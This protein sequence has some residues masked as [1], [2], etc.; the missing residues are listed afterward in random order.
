MDAIPASIRPRASSMSTRSSTSSPIPPR[1][2]APPRR[3][4]G[5]RS[6][7]GGTD[8]GRIWPQ[9]GGRP[10][11]LDIVG[12]N[13]YHNNQWIHGG[14]PIDR[15]HPLPRPFHRILADTYARYGRPI[16]VAE[17]GIEGDE[18]PAGWR[19]SPARSNWRGVG[20]AGGGHL[21]VPDP[22]PSRLGRR[23]AMPQRP[24]PH[25]P[26]R[27]A[28]RPRLCRGAGG[29][30]PVCMTMTALRWRHGTGTLYRRFRRTS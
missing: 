2:G 15:H 3:G 18:R 23:T 19:I 16:F 5:R 7:R 13:Y 21:P 11:L 20:R 1:P 9:I 8:S 29:D 17:T 6:S 12:V 30:H 10:D 25:R 24:T 27:P 26:G 28:A 4:T 22:R 14:P